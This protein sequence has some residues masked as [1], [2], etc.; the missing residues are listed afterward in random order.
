[1]RRFFLF[2]AVPL[3]LGGVAR[4]EAPLDCASAAFKKVLL[5]KPNF[6]FDCVEAVR[7]ASPVDGGNWTIRALRH[8]AT[9]GGQIQP[10]ADLAVETTVKAFKIW[11][12]Y[13]NDL[14]LKFRNVSIVFVDPLESE[15][16]FIAEVHGLGKVVGSAHADG[17]SLAEECVISINTPILLQTE[18]IF[19][20]QVFAHELFHCVQRWSFGAANDAGP[21]AAW[22]QE[23][24]ANLFASMVGSDAALFQA[25]GSA[26]LGSI[27]EKP[28]TQQSY[29]SI[30]FFAWLWQQGLKTTG[31]LFK[32]LAT[33]PGEAAQ[34]AAVEAALGEDLLDAFARALADGTIALPNGFEFDALVPVPAKIH[35]FTMDGQWEASKIPFTVD[36]H[37]L[38]FLGGSFAVSDPVRYDVRREG[39][40]DWGEMPIT[41]EPQ[42]CK[43]EQV[44]IAARF[45]T[46]KLADSYGLPV[47][48][49]RYAECHICQ[50]LPEADQCLIG[51]WKLRN[52]SL[53]A[54]L[55]LVADKTKNVRYSTAAGTVQLVVT[56]DGQAQWVTQ[57]LDI[58]A[59]V[60][61][62]ELG[63][64]IE[65]EVEMDG[66]VTGRWSTGASE[67]HFCAES[68]AAKYTSRVRVPGMDED[69]VT[70]SLPLQDSYLTYE[71]HPGTLTAVYTGPEEVAGP[72][73]SWTLDRIK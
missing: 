6:S 66:I 62:P 29:N 64:E 30:V 5:L 71:C 37:Q 24:S 14:G 27:H 36:L 67:M 25:M 65:I 41:I 38:N 57:G 8:K 73:P 60:F 42:D 19:Q 46:S 16:N 54:Y 44:F 22:W 11:E 49:S 61:V 13:A 17:F 56:A 63:D 34:M 3:A 53:L 45:V 39:S 1:M 28:L 48:A 15:I 35:T 70:D 43:E 23:G 55:K 47:F 10:Y 58:G 31:S 4:A 52:D 33:Q 40:A 12:T 7:I 18:L 20:E 21:T 26:F 2:L 32:G 59:Q 68:I 51:T 69:V 72:A 9:D 50:A